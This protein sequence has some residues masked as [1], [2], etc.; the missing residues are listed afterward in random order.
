MTEEI[1]GR[2]VAIKE[3]FLDWRL[4]TPPVL[5]FS[6]PEGY[7]VHVYPG[8]PDR[9][10]QHYGFTVWWAD[11]EL[12]E[13]AEHYSDLGTSIARVAAIARGANEDLQFADGPIYF[14]RWSENFFR[15]TL[16]PAK[17]DV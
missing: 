13:W 9:N 4:E 11:G 5:T 8:A 17:L 16:T 10:E 12:H 1:E 7:I 15:Q 2:D 14:T 6:A 3:G